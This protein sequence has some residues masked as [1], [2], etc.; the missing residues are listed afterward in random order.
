VELS[1]RK[2]R[3]LCA[4]VEFYNQ[5][6]E[7]VGSKRLMELLPD[8]LSSA[9]IRNEMAQLAE[10]G[11]L[12]QPHTSAGRAPSPLAYRFYIERL[13]PG[14]ALNPAQCRELEARLRER[15]REPERLLE[16]AGKLLAELTDCTALCVAHGGAD[17][18]LRR[19][20]MV[21]V[22]KRM[23]MVALLSDRGVVKS[24]IIRIECE[25]TAETREAFGNLT[26]TH[27]LG[28][29]LAE[30]NRAAMQSLAVQAGEQ[31]LPMIALLA[32]VAE[33]AR[34]AAEQE[35]LV[36]D[37]GGL[38]QQELERSAALLLRQLWESTARQQTGGIGVALG[39]EAPQPSPA[40]REMSLIVSPYSIGGAACG[41]LGILGPLRLDYANVIP[42][43]RFVTE[44]VGG[45]LSQ[46]LEE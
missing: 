9:T 46:S 1:E 11:F 30:I 2:R 42:S 43:L 44:L 40:L 31:M 12:E 7:P 18:K 25:L 5:T 37:S 19:L 6:G 33:L 13:L 23:A 38:P 35:M 36:G 27:L 41:L 28:R 26:Q 17:S 45:L 4:V 21:P 8:A 15:A 14:R 3:I 16:N 29:P 39:A 22:G 32:A 10:L 24:R 20:E 34:E